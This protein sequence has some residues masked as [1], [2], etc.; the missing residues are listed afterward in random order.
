MWGADSAAEIERHGDEQ[1]SVAGEDLQ[2]PELSSR[3]PR[4]GGL[5]PGSGASA[6]EAGRDDPAAG[7]AASTDRDRSSDPHP[8]SSP[9]FQWRCTMTKRKLAAPQ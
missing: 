4:I 9:A 1:A 3:M 8:A 5:Q 6:Y 7:A 2:D